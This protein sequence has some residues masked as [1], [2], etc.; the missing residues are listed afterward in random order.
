MD[1]HKRRNFI[2]ELTFI[3]SRSSGKGGQH[4]NK[5]E[6]RVELRFNVDESNLLNEEEKYKIKTY[7]KNR[8]SQ[9]GVLRMYSQIHKSQFQNKKRVIQ[10][11]HDL[12]DKA[13]A[14]RKKRIP[15][16]PSRV[17]KEKRLKEK[18]ITSEKKKTRSKDIF[19]DK[20]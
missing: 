8:V 13:L 17:A 15:T 11:F 6:S 4:V 1:Y 9:E 5:T 18:L 12:L 16:K 14:P 3:T 19:K 2:P 7:L 20:M 10:R